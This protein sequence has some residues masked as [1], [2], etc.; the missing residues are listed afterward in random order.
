MHTLFGVF[1]TKALN[2]NHKRYDK[3][4]GDDDDDEENSGVLGSI[5]VRML[6]KSHDR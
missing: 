1:C 2:I 3:E 4:G 6:L 5:T